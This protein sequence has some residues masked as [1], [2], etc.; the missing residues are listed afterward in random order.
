MVKDIDVFTI[1]GLPAYDENNNL[2]SQQTIDSDGDKRKYTWTYDESGNKLTERY[3]SS[4]G[5]TDYCEYTYDEDGN[6]L[7]KKEENYKGEMEV[8]VR[9][10]YDKHG[11]L[12]KEKRGASERADEIQFTYDSQGKL[13]QRCFI[14]YGWGNYTDETYTRYA[15]DE[16]GNLIKAGSG[17][18]YSDY[19]AFYCPRENR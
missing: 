7:V 8:A 13:I 15:Y 16:D 3:W 19:I 9:Y 5:Y 14:E 10:S 4:S 17:T 11:N 18:T 1:S 12:V 2:I 6:L